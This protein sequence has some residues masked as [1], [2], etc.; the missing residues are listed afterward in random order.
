MKSFP[1]AIVKTKQE[2][3]NVYVEPQVLVNLFIDFLEVRT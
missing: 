3:R 2:H 1:A